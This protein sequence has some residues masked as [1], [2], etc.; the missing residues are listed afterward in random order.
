MSVLLMMASVFANEPDRD[1]TLI[2]AQID[3]EGGIMRRQIRGVCQDERGFVWVGTLNGL[4]R[5]NGRDVTE[6]LMDP[7]DPSSLSGNGIWAVYA[8]GAGN[9]WAGTWGDGLNRINIYNGEIKRFHHDSGDIHSIPDDRIRALHMDRKGRLWIGTEGSGIAIFDPAA[10]K[11]HHLDGYGGTENDIAQPV[12]C[13]REDKQ[14]RIWAATRLGLYSFEEKGARLRKVWPSGNAGQMVRSLLCGGDGN[15]WLAAQSG[16]VCFHPEEGERRVYRSGDKDPHL[17]LQNA[18]PSALLEDRDGSVW[19]GFIDNGGLDRIGTDKRSIT[20]FPP[21]AAGDRGIADD[22]ITTL[23]Q[24]DSG[25]IWMGHMDIGGLAVVNPRRRIT[26][27]RCYETEGE[28]I[29]GSEVKTIFR[30]SGGNMWFGTDRGVDRF[31]PAAGKWTHFNWGEADSGQ[32]PMTRIWDILETHDGRILVGTWGRGVTILDPHSGDV[33]RL[34]ALMEGVTVYPHPV[35]IDLHVDKKNRL[36]IG[37]DGGGLE[38]W[39]LERSRIKRYRHDPEN[40]SSISSDIVM[41]ICEAGDGGLWV[42]TWG[43]G[44]NRLAA[45]GSGFSVYRYHAD[46]PGSLSNDTVFCAFRDRKGDVWIGTHGGGLNRLDTRTGTFRRYTKANGLPDNQI[47]SIVDDG[48]GSLWI[49]SASGLAR[50]DP[51]SGRIRAYDQRDGLLSQGFNIGASFRDSSGRL[52]FGGVAGVT[53]FQPDDFKA[54]SHVPPVWF[55]R[56]EVFE[57]HEVRHCLPDIPR[58]RMG[59]RESFQVGFSALDYSNPIH[60]RY[61]YRLES[62]SGDWIDLGDR[63][64]ITFAGMQPGH[65]LLQVR[66]CTSDGVWNNTGA[67]LRIAVMPPF[68]MSWWF[69]LLILSAL[70]GLFVYWHRTR[71]ARQAG[72]LRQER[73]VEVFCRRFGITERER[74]VLILLLKGMDRA[75]IAEKMI[76]SDATVKNHIYSLYRKLKV[77]SRAQLFGMFGAMK[78]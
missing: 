44:L 63:N 56:L 28:G 68:W 48:E 72:R 32:F 11:S 49:A 19:V 29:S 52:Y 36:W 60:N 23:F 58:V 47:M 1:Y 42:G 21:R 76:I 78:N 34:H 69:R 18:Y 2:P 77:N 12:Y 15:I 7:G 50:L 8:D 53:A 73:E 57:Q 41:T 30:D 62:A 61:A 66:G 37:T 10:E 16:V 64:R 26:Y 38:C 75:A 6:F 74:E 51:Q 71:M 5:C 65:Y 67:R 22:G 39:D 20:H 55:T 54:G 3:L 45:D 31:D 46:D 70:V 4:V 59:Y 40:P 35:V 27:Y 43:G 33:Q 13:I 24:D 14:G 9:I 17:R 25:L